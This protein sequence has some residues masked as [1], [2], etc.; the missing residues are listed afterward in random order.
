MKEAYYYCI[1]FMLFSKKFL[2]FCLLFII[3]II[4]LSLGQLVNAQVGLES[5]TGMNDI[6]QAYGG[7]S[8]QDLRTL[9][10]KIVRVILGFLGVIFIGLLVFSGFKYM[11]AGGNEEDTKK[12]TAMIKNSVIGLIIILSAWAIS[13]YIVLMLVQ[14]SHV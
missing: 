12:A 6:E 14:A 10:A 7:Y 2:S 4:I 9:A 1:T 13:H 11:T 5:Q 8:N 3:T